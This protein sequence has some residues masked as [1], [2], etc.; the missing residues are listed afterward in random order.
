M[1]AEVVA[2]PMYLRRK[3]LRTLAILDRDVAEDLRV[4]GPRAINR[5]S[6]D[7]DRYPA[8]RGVPLH[9]LVLGLKKY[10]PGV[11]HHLDAVRWNCTRTNLWVCADSHE[12]GAIWHSP[13]Y[14]DL[15]AYKQARSYQARLHFR[16]PPTSVYFD[17]DA[18]PEFLIARAY[19][20]KERKVIALNEQIAE[21]ES[22]LEGAAA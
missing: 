3:R 20:K 11:V 12:H 9:R 7:G 14:Y 13:S 6:Y 1:S 19:R 5:L 22:L 15:A 4:Y 17:L 8:F 18:I 2:I 10:D 16:Q 21:L